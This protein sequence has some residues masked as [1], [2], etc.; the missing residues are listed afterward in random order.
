MTNWVIYLEP[1]GSGEKADMFL[2]GKHIGTSRQ[3]IY[4]AARA[5]LKMGKDPSATVETRRN[6]V[7]CMT[8]V[9]G[10]LATRSVSE[11]DR[12]TITTIPF[13]PDMRFPSSP[14]PQK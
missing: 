9:I 13:N 1:A 2:N 14:S 11:P 10:R 7:T 8:G 12:T 6:G 3:P 5:L 4:A